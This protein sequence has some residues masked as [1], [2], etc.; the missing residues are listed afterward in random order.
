MIL[1]LSSLLKYV[2]VSIVLHAY[3][4]KKKIPRIEI[5]YLIRS[6]KLG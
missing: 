3:F 4:L 6:V 2:E 5:Y 1:A